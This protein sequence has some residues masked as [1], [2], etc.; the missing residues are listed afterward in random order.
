MG[1]FSR[2]GEILV[3]GLVEKMSS[4]SSSPNS[5]DLLEDLLAGAT[6]VEVGKADGLVDGG[7]LL[8]KEVAADAGSGMEG[9]GSTGLPAFGLIENGS[10]SSSSSSNSPPLGLGG[11]TLTADGPTEGGGGPLPRSGDTWGV[12]PPPPTGGPLD[13]G[14]T[15]PKSSSSSPPP[16]SM[17]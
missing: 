13:G 1:M 4:S 17:L 15:S 10:S 5:N 14:L 8:E 16:N 7:K 2:G 3:A 11:D 9:C 12:S 6:V